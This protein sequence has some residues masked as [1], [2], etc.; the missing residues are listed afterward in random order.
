MRKDGSGAERRLRHTAFRYCRGGAALRATSC[1]KASA[2]ATGRQEAIK[3]F[4]STQELREDG[5]GR[6]KQ[7]T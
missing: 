6:A 2:V 3:E 4:D 1:R 7:N 5:F